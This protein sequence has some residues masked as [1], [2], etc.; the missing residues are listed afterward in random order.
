MVNLVA[1]STDE[2]RIKTDFPCRIESWP[3][4]R[5]PLSDGNWLHA[6]AWLPDDATSCPVP[7]LIEY[8][9]FRHRDFTAPR[10]AL[11]HPWFA[12]HGYA[13]LRVELRGSGDSSGLPLDE[14]LQQE[15]DDAVEALAWIAAQTWCDGNTGMF[16]MSW[17]AFSALQVAARNPPSLKAIIP[18]HGT[19]DRF[20]DDIHYKGGCLQ[21]AGLSWGVLQT[22]YSMRPPDPDISGSA[23]QEEWLARFEGCPLVLAQWMAHQHKDEYWR[24]GSIGEDY[25]SL[26]CPALVV[27]GWAD[28]YTNAAMR[29]AAELPADSRVWIGPWA[30]TYPHIAQPGP[31][32]GFLQEALAW[33]ERWLKG[34]I[35]GVDPL[36][37]V[38]VWLQDSTPP[39]SCYTRRDGEWLGLDRWPPSAATT[40]NWYLQPN[41]LDET[42]GSESVLQV[43]TPLANGISGA[44]WLPHGVG[45]ELPIDQRREDAGSLCFDTRVLASELILCG[46][47]VVKLKIRSDT[48]QG[49]LQVRLIDVFADGS[50]A[51]ISYGLINLAHRQGLDQPRPMVPGEW[52]EVCM[53]LNDIAQRLPA[54][55]Q[56]RVSISTQ[57]WPLV[58]PAP[59]IMTLELMTG[60]CSFEI[61]VI[62]ADKL[63]GLRIDADHA[64]EI[65]R[66]LALDWLRPVN[67]RRDI[68]IDADAGTV[69]RTYIK[70]DGAYRIVEHGMEID[71]LGKLIY[72]CRGEDP[73][74]AE[75]EYRYRI[76]FARNDWQV[77]VE[78]DLRIT[79]D[80]DNFYLSGEYRA[81]EGERV[82]KRRKVNLP[83]TRKFV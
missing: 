40:R 23:W 13:S 12:G 8:A 65:P 26:T 14:Y 10:D 79:A 59:E 15:Q 36:P 62:E 9:P 37:R 83:V 11:I 70:D 48:G 63:P 72:R 60:S 56:L 47:G 29:M 41:R 22:L 82:I 51:Q 35:N 50:A 42:P 25:A 52:T 6:R 46:A 3:D 75:A 34:K 18:V 67:R 19:D 24:H 61:P 73:L 76:G 66:P 68:E 54:G 53:Q 28:G 20:A 30:H 27:C 4:I 31:Q 57:A 38:R 32:G 21:G 39:A 2:L 55:H 44:E 7:A 17:G 64:A 49:L 5:I 45:P 78:C 16:G 1:A 69:C 80:L 81:L 77:S 71:A 43:K 33:W 74:S 58:W